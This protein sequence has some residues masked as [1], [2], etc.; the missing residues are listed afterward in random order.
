MSKF[1]IH[2]IFIV[3][4]IISFIGGYFTKQYFTPEVKIIA[5]ETVF[6]TID[7]K[8]ID[9][10]PVIELKKEVKLAYTAPFIIDINH[11]QGNIYNAHAVVGKRYADKEFRM[12]VSESG[13]FKLYLGIG[14]GVVGTA[15][16]GYLIYRVVR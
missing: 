1:Y 15:G 6:N 9:T 4:L 14:I 7:T 16:I 13:N 2:I 8:V 5:K 3:L 12:E 11:I 10:M